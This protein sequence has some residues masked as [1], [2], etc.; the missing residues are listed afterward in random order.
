MLW[1]GVAYTILD[2]ILPTIA[3]IFIFRYPVGALIKSARNFVGLIFKLGTWILQ[4]A[5]A[6]AS[7]LATWHSWKG[8]ATDD[9]AIAWLAVSLLYGLLNIYL[10]VL[11]SQMVLRQ[12]PEQT[13]LVEEAA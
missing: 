7:A 10:A 3:S 8:P 12:I 13:F 2:I 6:P 4:E 5:H 1:V 9:W 11:V